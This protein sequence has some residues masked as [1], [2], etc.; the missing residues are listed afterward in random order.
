MYFI[1][2]VKRKERAADNALWLKTLSVFAKNMCSV[3]GTHTR[4]LKKHLKPW[5]QVFRPSF[6]VPV[7]IHMYMVHI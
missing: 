3:P 1:M 2:K 7:D 6:L 4:W 5:S